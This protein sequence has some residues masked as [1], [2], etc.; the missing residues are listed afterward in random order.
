LIPGRV[1]IVA[2]SSHNK[3]CHP[4]PPGDRW[5]LWRGPAYERPVRLGDGELGAEAVVV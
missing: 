2:R 5:W 4:A 3:L 1:F